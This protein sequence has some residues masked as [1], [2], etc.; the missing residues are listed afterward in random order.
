[1]L[2]FFFF[3]FFFLSTTFNEKLWLNNTY[4]ATPGLINGTGS[5]EKK[6]PYNSTLITVY[7]LCT[8]TL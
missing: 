1:M 2:L 8:E 4:L 7:V 6:T 5:F 3:C